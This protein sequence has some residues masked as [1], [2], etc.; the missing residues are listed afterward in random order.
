MAVNEAFCFD[1]KN[2]RFMLKL[3]CTIHQIVFAYYA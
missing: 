2:W 3:N 1:T